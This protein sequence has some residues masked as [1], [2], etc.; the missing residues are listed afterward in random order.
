[1]IV[2]TAAADTLM[3]I[4]GFKKMTEKKAIQSQSLKDFIDRGMRDGYIVLDPN[5]EH[6]YLTKDHSQRIPYQK[7]AFGGDDPFVCE[8]H[9]L[10]LLEV[11]LNSFQPQC[12]EIGSGVIHFRKLPTWE[13]NFFSTRFCMTSKDQ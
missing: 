9:M 4:F 6:S 12:Y 10:K 13:G 11:T 2:N 7:Y 5:H 8:L 3:G 1:M